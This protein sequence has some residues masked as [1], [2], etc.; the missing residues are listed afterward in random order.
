MGMAAPATSEIFSILN[1]LACFSALWGKD[2]W[3]Y[4]P[5]APFPPHS[6]QQ[7]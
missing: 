6:R 4:D 1:T 7:W 3:G 2:A 5:I